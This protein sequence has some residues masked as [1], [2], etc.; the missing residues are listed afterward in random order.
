ML[1]YPNVLDGTIKLHTF[2]R[3]LNTSNKQNCLFA[4]EE[5]A[6]TFYIVEGD[7]QRIFYK[8]TMKFETLVL[9]MHF[10]TPKHSE[11]RDQFSLQRR[12]YS[13]FK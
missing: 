1:K 12:N 13:F 7:T 3:L 2:A 10:Q 6:F 11:K 9:P 5:N 8:E 4:V